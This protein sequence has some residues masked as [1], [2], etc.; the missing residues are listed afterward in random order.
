MNHRSSGLLGG[1][2]PTLGLA[3]RSAE[4]S[5]GLTFPRLSDAET[6]MNPT[7]K[8]RF[9]GALM[10]AVLGPIYCLQWEPVEAG[11]KQPC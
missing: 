10:G 2:N 11:G 6:E 1:L 3:W 7:P 9:Q 5:Y 8:N 4:R